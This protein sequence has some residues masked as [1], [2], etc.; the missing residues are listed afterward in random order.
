[1]S[2]STDQAGYQWL[3][4]AAMAARKAGAPHV[5]AYWL[6]SPS[7]AAMAAAFS[8]AGQAKSGKPWARFTAP[9]RSAIRVMSRITD[10]VKRPALA[11]VRGIVPPSG[12]RPAALAV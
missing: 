12:D 2:G 6:T 9:W 3:V 11:E 8:S 4:L 7:M 10:S 1:M 5:M